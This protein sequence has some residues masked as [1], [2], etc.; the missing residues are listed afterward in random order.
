M[1]MAASAT[2]AKDIPALTPVRIEIL[3][4]LGSATSHSLDTFPIRLAEPIVIDGVEVV[5]AGTTGQ[6]EVVHAKKAGGSGTPGELVLAARWIDACGQQLKLRSMNFAAA[7][8]GA[9]GT[10]NTVNAVSAATLLPI[11]LIG[12]AISGRNVTYASGTLASAKIALAVPGT[13]PR[14]FSATTIPTTDLEKR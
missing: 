14:P 13:D 9:I 11:G 10:V 2:C 12:F 4:D 6:G 3:A 8:A 1:P 7:G 5:P